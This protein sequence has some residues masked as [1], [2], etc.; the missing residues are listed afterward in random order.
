MIPALA[1]AW[2]DDFLPIVQRICSPNEPGHGYFKGTSACLSALY[3]AGRH[4]ELLA[5]LDHARFKWWH[6]RRWG[7]RALLAQGRKSEALRYAE[8]SRGL[9]APDGQISAACEEILLSSGLVDEAYQRYAVAAGQGMTH[10]ATF[11]AIAKK[12]PHKAPADILRDLV[13]SQPGSEGK[14]FA[15]A[16]D[17]G[18]YDL[19]IDLVSRSP[20]DPRTLIRAARDH[21]ESQPRFAMSAGMAALRWIARGHGYEITGIDVLDAYQAVIKAT[22]AAEMGEPETR[23]EIRQIIDGTDPYRQFLCKVLAHHLAAPDLKF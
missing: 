9:N 12:Y 5:L 21:A 14:W 10:L 7:V 20:A 6:D 8:D 19:A 23:E 4:D 15:A 11:R 1:S 2:A 18:L 13:S 3:A 22:R 17:A 16:K